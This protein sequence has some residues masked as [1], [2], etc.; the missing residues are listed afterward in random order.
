MGKCIYCN[1]KIPSDLVG[2]C[3]GCWWKYHANAHVDP[4]ELKNND[5]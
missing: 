1:K 3:S 4:L 2:F 5:H